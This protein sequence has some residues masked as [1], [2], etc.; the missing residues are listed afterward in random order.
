[1]G[2]I[3]KIVNIENDKVYIGLTANTIKWRWQ[4][5][6]QE[7]RTTSNKILYKAI[8]KYGEE[9]FSIEQL[10]EVDNEEL[11]D[12][13]IYW[14]KYYDS[15]IPNGYN[16]T[17]GGE[18]G[19][20]YDR[21]KIIAYYLESKN[22]LS[23]QDVATYF[24]MHR[25]TASRILRDG[26]IELKGSGQSS[27]A[28]SSKK[29]YQFNKETK[30]LLNDFPSTAEA[31]RQLGDFNYSSSISKCCRGK[32]KTAYGFYWEYEKEKENNG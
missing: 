24:N 31:A 3:Y 27:G 11:E 19:T 17:F 29:V 21:E 1:M 10:E 32:L 13:E 18:H 2:Y 8:R 30:E 25:E 22:Y 14:I 12:R 20:F 5:H 15:M 28:K 26:G 4:K 9:K 23:I 16:M 6:L 7:S